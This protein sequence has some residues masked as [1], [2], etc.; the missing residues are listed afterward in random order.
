MDFGLASSKSW[1]K[2]L[3]FIA[4]M[5]SRRQCLRKIVIDYRPSHWDPKEDD[6]NPVTAAK[7]NLPWSDRLSRI[8]PFV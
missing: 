1:G 5:D 7:V 3:E 6:F 4:G 2:Y 8:W